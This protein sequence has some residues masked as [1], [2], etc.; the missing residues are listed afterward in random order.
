MHCVHCTTHKTNVNATLIG[1]VNRSN[2]F[3]QFENMAI[4]IKKK[5]MANDLT[6]HNNNNS[7]SLFWCLLY[8]SGNS[9][10]QR[11]Q[12]WR[13]HGSL[14][15]K[16]NK[17][18]GNIDRQDEKTLFNEFY[19]PIKLVLNSCFVAHSFRSFSRFCVFFCVSLVFECRATRIVQYLL[20]IKSNKNIIIYFNSIFFSL[21]RSSWLFEH[22][23]W[24]MVSNR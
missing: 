22:I 11:S 16:Y 4:S 23:M 18:L 5:S 17:I 13:R 12:W 24:S 3:H 6:N 9:W 8:A 7:E 14:L 20:F 1:N 19:R 15:I 2:Q 21:H 10:T